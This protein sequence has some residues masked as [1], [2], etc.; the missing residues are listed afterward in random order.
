MHET[1]TVVWNFNNFGCHVFAKLWNSSNYEDWMAKNKVKFTN[2]VKYILLF[3]P[4]VCP[5][6][7]L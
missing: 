2:T 4:Q 6:N 1:K 5:F 7:Y 3:V